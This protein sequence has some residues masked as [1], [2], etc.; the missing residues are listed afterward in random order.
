MHGQFGFKCAGDRDA[1]GS[2][3]SEVLGTMRMWIFPVACSL[4]CVQNKESEARR[5]QERLEDE[6]S[7]C[8]SGSDIEVS[9]LRGVLETSRAL[10]FLMFNAICKSL[11]IKVSAK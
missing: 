4:W 10:A 5:E 6:S 1:F 3:F 8:Q 7:V 11:W 9:S 2:A